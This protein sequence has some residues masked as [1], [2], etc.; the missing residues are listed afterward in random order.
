MKKKTPKSNLLVEINNR[1]KA[2]QK[3]GNKPESFDKFKPGKQRNQN[4]SSVGPSWGGRK[5][6]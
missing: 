6:N 2:E 3:S 5:G 1:K 4:N